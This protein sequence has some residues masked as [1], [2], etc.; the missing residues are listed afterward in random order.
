MTKLFIDIVA[1]SKRHLDFT[2]H[3]FA[4]PEDASEAAQLIS[5]DL[6]VAEDSPWAGGQVQVKDE[7]GQCLFSY[8]VQQL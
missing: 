3:M 8:P 2:G 7:A 6:G 1:P 5:L 4:R